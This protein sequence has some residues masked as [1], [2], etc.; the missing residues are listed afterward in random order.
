MTVVFNSSRNVFILA[1]C[2]FSTLLKASLSI[3]DCS[4][5][6][7]NDN[8]ELDS[9]ICSRL[10]TDLKNDS[11][12]VGL[13]D[14]GVDCVTFVGSTVE[15]ESSPDAPDVLVVDESAPEPRAVPSWL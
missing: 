9:S 4:S 5:I 2:R 3:R 12:V 10:L 1:I 11:C 8:V 6:Y 7:S 15:V 14:G 13:G